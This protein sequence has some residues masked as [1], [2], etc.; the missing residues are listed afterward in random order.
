MH[1]FS[2]EQAEEEALSNKPR[3]KQKTASANQLAIRKDQVL[4]LISKDPS[5]WWWGQVYDTQRRELIGTEGW[6]PSNYVKKYYSTLTPAEEDPQLKALAENPADLINLCYTTNKSPAQA[7]AMS[8]VTHFKGLPLLETVKDHPEPHHKEVRLMNHFFDYDQWNDHMN[9][10]DPARRKGRPDKR[11]KRPK[12][13][14][15]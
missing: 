10:I 13:I 3:K 9:K 2:P 11:L 15:W 4:K 14:R 6:F 8:S 7:L 5:G 1:D 12:K